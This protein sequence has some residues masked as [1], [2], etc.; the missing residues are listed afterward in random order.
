MGKLR[1][2][3]KD[4]VFAEVDRLIRAFHSNLAPEGTTPPWPFGKW[5]DRQGLGS[6]FLDIGEAAEYERCVNDLQRWLG[7]VPEPDVS[8][9]SRKRVDGLLQTAVLTSLDLRGESELAFDERV[10]EA[11]TRLEAEMKSGLDE[12]LFVLE[13][14]S[15]KPASGRFDFGGVE[16]TLLEGERLEDLRARLDER[17]DETA[18]TPEN[19]EKIKAVIGGDVS[20]NL[21]G[22]LVA[23]TSVKA[24]DNNAASDLGRARVQAAIDVLNCLSVLTFPHRPYMHLAGDAHAGSD[25]SVV[26]G[27]KGASV[28]RSHAGPYPLELERLVHEGPA[29]DLLSRASALLV[30]KRS[31]TLDK[32]LMAAMRWVGRAMREQT[33]EQQLL[34]YA[35][36]LESM[37]L[38]PGTTHEL[39]HQL[40]VRA[41]HV[42]GPTPAIRI[43]L[44][45]QV[46]DIYDIRSQLVHNGA[47]LVTLGNVQ[48]ARLIA[49]GCILRLLSDEPFRQMTSFEDLDSWFRE[50]IMA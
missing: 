27:T 40:A 35:I 2:P 29:K 45:K 41:A 5:F 46:R 26:L 22:Q 33:P 4:E 20:D 3:Q 11:I 32:G 38:G 50:R 18:D 13:V 15:A 37:L 28:P 8:N 30:A 25:L 49:S 43:D 17:F 31:A 7:N 19:K 47:Y 24:Y 42:L 34:G 44:E 23:L 12:W 10:A 21:A 39:R 48:Y 9:I 36:A 6:L 1:V 16:F 14:H